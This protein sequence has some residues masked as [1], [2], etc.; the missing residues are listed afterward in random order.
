VTRIIALLCK[1][2]I[3]MGAD[4]KATEAV[5][6]QM[7]LDP[8]LPVDKVVQLGDRIIWGGSGEVGFIDGEQVSQC[9]QVL[10]V[11]DHQTDA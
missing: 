8:S 6:G 7:A 1:D 3:V 4:S 11:S 2:A 10:V 5:T 9:F